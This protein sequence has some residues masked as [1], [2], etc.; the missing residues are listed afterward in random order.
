MALKNAYSKMPINRVFD[1]ITKILVA[2]KAKKIMMDYDNGRI[3]AVF[4]VI[5][6]QGKDL[7]IKL[8]A[9]TSNVKRVLEEQGFRYD[10]E[11]IYRVAW[12]NI[13][14]WIDAQMAMI[15]TEMAKMEEVFLPYIASG[16]QT[17]FEYLEGTGFISLPSQ[18]SS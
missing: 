7:P 12:R 8:P 17:Y 9:R 5:E 11:Q 3:C 13:L 2:H 16:D 15:D 18:I 10:D 6:A 4:F 1:A 14:S